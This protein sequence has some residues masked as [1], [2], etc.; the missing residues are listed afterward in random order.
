MQLP[1]TTKGPGDLVTSKFHLIK[2]FAPNLV[3]GRRTPLGLGE[4]ALNG[5]KLRLAAEVR[6]QV[7]RKQYYTICI[8]L[9]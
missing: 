9:S 3:T 4:K 1:G 2:N 8:G 6:C 7:A 5:E